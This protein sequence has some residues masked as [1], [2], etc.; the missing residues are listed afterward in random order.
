[1]LPRRHSL[2]YVEVGEQ[3]MYKTLGAARGGD[4]RFYVEGPGSTSGDVFW[5]RS[6]EVRRLARLRP[7]GPV[8]ARSVWRDLMKVTRLRPPVGAV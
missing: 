8:I 1:M 3:L 5:W 2:L 4:L 6:G 7:S